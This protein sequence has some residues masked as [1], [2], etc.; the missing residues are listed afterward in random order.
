[1]EVIFRSAEAVVRR[2]G[3]NVEGDGYVKGKSD[4]EGNEV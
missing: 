4:G 3:R 2:R 1:M